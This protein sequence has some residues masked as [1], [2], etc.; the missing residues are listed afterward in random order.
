MDN[1]RV[2]FAAHAD[3]RAVHDGD[4][5]NG[6]SVESDVSHKSEDRQDAGEFAR[7]F[8][9]E[10]LRPPIVLP[11]PSPHRARAASHKWGDFPKAPA[12]HM[13]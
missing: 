5:K 12:Q 10:I 6:E 11:F 1:I 8:A 7:D 4:A 13:P 2:D 3:D 9:A